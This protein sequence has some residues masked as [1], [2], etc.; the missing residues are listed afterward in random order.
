[1]ARSTG[2]VIGPSLRP[3]PL[4]RLPGPVAG[5]PPEEPLH[6]RMAPRA[7]DR[8][9]EGGPAE[10][11]RAC[12]GRR[13]DLSECPNNLR[14]IDSTETD[15]HSYEEG[16]FRGGPPRATVSARGLALAKPA[17]HNEVVLG[18]VPSSTGS[19]SV[20]SSLLGRGTNQFADFFER[21][22]EFKTGRFRR[23]ITVEVNR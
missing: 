18:Q 14:Q 23:I 5:Q 7:P 8:L 22:R 11:G 10:G 19:G 15:S 16:P 2:G 20:L 13:G 9:R 21:F 3:E 17:A 12:A 6:E 1:M 4:D